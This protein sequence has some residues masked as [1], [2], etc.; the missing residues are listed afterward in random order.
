MRLT[1][2]DGLRGWGAVVVL[3]YHTFCDSL[4][5]ALEFKP[6][7]AFVLLN[8]PMAVSVFFAV[9]GFSLTVKY[10]ESGELSGWC[11]I[12]CG[13]YV[14][15]A[16]P[17]FAAC[18]IIHVA[19]VLGFMA[20]SAERMSSFHSSFLFEPTVWHL[21]R[22]ALWDVFFWYDW[23]ESYIGLLWTMGL[24]LIGSFL[25]LGLVFALRNVAWRFPAFVLIALAIA[26]FA[27]T[28]RYQYLALFPA[29]AA[30]AD[31]FNRRWLEKIPAMVAAGLIVVS[32]AQ[33]FFFKT[34]AGGI[35]LGALPLTLGCISFSPV[36][37]WLSAPLS[38]HLG[39]I[40]FPL[41]LTHGPVIILVGEPL[42]RQADSFA[43][44]IGIDLLVVVLSFA[45]AH[46]FVPVN[47]LAILASRAIGDLL[48]GQRAPKL[49]S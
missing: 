9:S 19:M 17:I 49:A 45:A 32:V 20:P 37:A 3:F 26:L 40:S 1:F 30:I 46:A 27:P 39:E 23:R 41:Y 36:R 7:Y 21:L 8:G 10:L 43:S 24:E 25:A 13:R 16:I 6:L 33:P 5:P 48:L 4:P 29:G 15:L 34:T 38:A 31:A 12:L 2:L 35:L 42:M 11:R 18:L 28:Y 47:K 14:R 22:F 44:R